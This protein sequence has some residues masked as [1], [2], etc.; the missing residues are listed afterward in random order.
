MSVIFRGRSPNGKRVSVIWNPYNRIDIL[1]MGN[2]HRKPLNDKTYD[3]LL[4]LD[5]VREDLVEAGYT[6]EE[7]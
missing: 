5:P 2:G 6:V 7:E 1:F 4:G 3:A